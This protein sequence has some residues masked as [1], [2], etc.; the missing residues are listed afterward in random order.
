MGFQAIQSTSKPA[1]LHCF[2]TYMPCLLQ[3][4]IKFQIRLLLLNLRLIRYK[5][6]W[7][8]LLQA[9]SI[10]H[11]SHR[12][13]AFLR[14]MTGPG[15]WEGEGEKTPDHMSWIERFMK[16]IPHQGRVVLFR[17]YHWHFPEFECSLSQRLSFTGRHKMFIRTLVKPG[18][19]L[20]TPCCTL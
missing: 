12:T 3:K 9:L 18:L 5:K 10:V 11:T 20:S 16:Q 13:A 1:T 15:S 6:A 14:Q 7:R 8:Y 4:F 17:P 19:P 2:Q